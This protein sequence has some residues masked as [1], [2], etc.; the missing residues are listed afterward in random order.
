MGEDDSRQKRN[1]E[2]SWKIHRIHWEK[3]RF[4][5]DLMYKR[6]TMSKAM[7]DWLIK[8]KIADKYLIE[9]WRQ[10]GFEFVCSLLAIQK[11]GHNFGTTSHCR[12]PVMQRPPHMSVTPNVKTGCISCF[13]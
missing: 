7:F 13:S 12:V 11:R 8:K 2:S 3:N 6:K 1:C 4:I 9:I 5:F 10:P